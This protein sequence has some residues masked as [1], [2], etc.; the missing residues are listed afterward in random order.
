MKQRLSQ[1][2]IVIFTLAVLSCD[3]LGPLL[4][5]KPKKPNVP[6][7]VE[8]MQKIAQA[9]FKGLLKDRKSF[10]IPSTITEIGKEALADNKLESITIPDAVKKLGEASLANN[11]LK[12]I[13]FG[14]GLEEIGKDALKN[15]QL[16]DITIPHGVKK[17]DPSS[18]TGNPLQNVTLP[19]DLYQKITNPAS[20]TT[21]NTA[22]NTTPPTNTANTKNPP[23]NTAAKQNATMNP[24]TLQKLQKFFPNAQH[25]RRAKKINGGILYT[26]QNYSENKVT[27]ELSIQDNA[28]IITQDMYK[29]N[30][31]N[32]VTIPHTTTKIEK[33]AFA[34]N[35]LAEVTIPN[36]VTDIEDGAFTGN[37]L[38]QVR[39]SDT[40][41]FKLHQAGR[42]GKVFGNSV[43]YLNPKTDLAH[44][45]HPILNKLQT[46]QIPKSITNIAPGD[47]SNLSNAE[48][49]SFETPSQIT[50]IPNGSFSNNAKL[51]QVEIP[52]S[53]KVI[54]ANAFSNNAELKRVSFL[55]GSQLKSIATGAFSGSPVDSV[56]LEE[57]L[58]NNNKLTNSFTSIFPS[59]TFYN[60][61]NTQQ[62]IKVTTQ[63]PDGT[64]TETLRKN[65]KHRK[66]VIK[67]DIDKLTATYSSEKLDE[68]ELGTKLTTIPVS[69][70][71][72]NK[73]TEVTIPDSVNDIGDN[74]F[75]GNPLTQVRLSDTLYFKLH[76]A[77]RL[78]KVFGN[79]V[80]HLNP[81]TDL[82]HSIQLILSKL[83]T[84]QISKSITNIT[85]RDYSNLSNAE[86]ISFETPSQITIIPSDSFSNNAK[87]KQVEIPVSVKIIQANAF[88]NNI[89]LKSVSFLQGS[90]LTNIATGA[91]SDSPI[92]TVYL[93]QALYARLA[94]ITSIFPKAKFYDITIKNKKQEIKN[95][96]GTQTLTTTSK[97]TNDG[98]II[99]TKE[100]G[101]T[102][103]RKFVM[104]DTS[105]QIAD[106]YSSKNLNEIELKQG[107]KK[108]PASVFKE[109]NLTQVT[110]PTSVTEIGDEAFS[111]NKLTS[112]VIPN[113]VIT[114]GIYAFDDN[115]LTEVTI[116]KSVS[117]I[118]D[119]AF[120]NN[121]LL[122]KVTL[123]DTLY[124]KLKTAKR[125]TVVF[126]TSK[127]IKYFNASR[128]K[129]F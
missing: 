98:V 128:G 43:K 34:N 42:L 32:K 31:L 54:Q 90:Q 86:S 110:I 124:N 14:K 62:K 25:Y 88:S 84:I 45:I 89:E 64:I 117:D 46:I 67:D 113:S 93:E 50:I 125:L 74:A 106:D 55:Q 28:S 109:N 108:I 44:S 120:T 101:I 116:P 59:A 23:T 47:Y 15:N 20:S 97:T 77:R 37:P 70:F 66:F 1:F 48:S 65:K 85:P 27:K 6:N 12:S 30:D 96:K 102:K 80:K 58:Y 115:K 60:I 78:G 11:K 22:N 121:P 53:V 9:M 122:T 4:T 18:F 95:Q 17:L 2:L 73:L 29:D 94:N 3:M 57:A 126:G 24:E 105:D 19:E 26:S 104:N 127:A 112:V 13:T 7:L 56:Y 61:N 41:Y 119:G 129:Q 63:K 49:I 71:A 87:L 79:S 40:L 52:P 75:T 92:A 5:Q 21:Q 118:G 51:K 39:L 114:I 83:K 72:N 69:A 68:V 38:T 16:T 91:F 123:S 81:K 10:T 99:T 76:Q 82:A 100:N 35:K 8:G 111:Y 36:S 33:N 107:L 103:H